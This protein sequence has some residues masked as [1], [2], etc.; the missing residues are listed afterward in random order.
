[1][2][3]DADGRHTAEDTLDLDDV[4]KRPPLYSWATCDEQ[5]LLDV[6]RREYGFELG[7]VFVR[8]FASEEADLSVYLWGNY[9]DVVEDPD[10][11]SD[12]D[13]HEEACASLAGYWMRDGN[14]VVLYGNDYWAGP[15]GT[16]H[17][18]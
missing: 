8:E 1:L 7:P 10:G 18:S 6:L 11:R 2:Q 16:I 4:L 17:T 5:E 13:E 9:E 14:F 15:D 3:F 12:G